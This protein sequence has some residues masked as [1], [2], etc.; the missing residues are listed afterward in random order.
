MVCALCKM[1]KRKPR[2]EVGDLKIGFEESAQEVQ[3]LLRK[4]IYTWR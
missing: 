4:F 1:S 3:R 2:V